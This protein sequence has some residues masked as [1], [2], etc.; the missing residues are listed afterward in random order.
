MLTN[1]IDGSAAITFDYND[2]D[3]VGNRLSCKIDDDAAHAYEY[4]E[5]YRLTY[6]DYNYDNTTS[7]N[8]DS[9]GNRTSVTHVVGIICYLCIS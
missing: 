2:Y 5:L 8:Y 3:K 9:L 1:N 4:D 6:V 7:Y